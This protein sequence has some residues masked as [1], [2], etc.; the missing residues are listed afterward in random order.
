[1]KQPIRTNNRAFT[2]I[3]L[4]VVIAII[5]ILAGMLLP[6]LA[7]AKAKAQRI[8][9]TSNLKQTALAFKM[10]S[11]DNDE[12][13]PHQLSR[14]LFAS[15]NSNPWRIFTMMS[16]EVASPKILICPG[17]VLR[18][19]SAAQDFST[20]SVGLQS[21]TNAAL[22]YFVGLRADE[23]MPQ[24]ILLG[25]RHIGLDDTQVYYNTSTPYTT[26]ALNGAIVKSPAAANNNV[27]VWSR[28]AA[29]GISAPHEGVGN[30]ALGDGSVQ[31]A[32]I[33]RLNDQLLI[34]SNSQANA[35][36]NLMSF[37]QNAATGTP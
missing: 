36:A 23:S 16:N 22:S 21:L 14:N 3:E 1:M 10:F 34:S 24:S 32:T 33:D 31:N 2:L 19:G 29:A 25:D 8:K 26:N 17:D 28:Y 30:L 11:G 4:L 9:C 13:Y 27:V 37:P 15:S 35:Q 6:A 7:K 5:A 12:K 20:N 18:L